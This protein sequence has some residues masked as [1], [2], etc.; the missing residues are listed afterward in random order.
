M[1]LLMA[2]VVA[3][4]AACTVPAEPDPA[5]SRA[6]PLAPERSDAPAKVPVTPARVTRHIDGDTFEVSVR[7]RRE[8]VRFIGMDTPER[9]VP[10][11]GAA[12][13]FTA[14]QAPVGSRVFLE[15]DVERRDRFGRLLAYVWLDPPSARA[16]PEVRASMLNA[17]LVARG[18][19]TIL[20]IPPNVGYAEV[21]ISLQRAARRLQRGLW[22]SPL[23]RTC[24]PSYPGVCISPPPPD[25]DCADVTER[26]FRVRA[27]DPHRFDMDGN[28]RGCE[29]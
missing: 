12:A 9:G 21:F 25:L 24:D 5:G 8:S 17:R 18:L 16:R 22:G 4:C 28:G 11:F 3:A 2:L 15:F 7:D 26:N 19:A 20:T 6:A 1:R 13:A 10:F 23:L 29:S 27:P 14:R